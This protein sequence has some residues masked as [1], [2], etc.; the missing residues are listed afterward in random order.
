[1]SRP[2]PFALACGLI[3]LGSALLSATSAGAQTADEKTKAQAEI[4]TKEQ[5]V[6]YG[7]ADGNMNNYM[8]ATHPDYMAWP[9]WAEA[10]FG[11]EGLKRT[12]STLGGD[13]EKLAME[14][15]DFTM[16]GDTALIYYKTHRTALGD[17]TPV[18]QVYENIHVW[19]RDGG[20]WKVMGGMAREKAKPKAP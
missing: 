9:P 10:P 15:K 6:Y 19:K 4:W 20:E 3:L 8:Q 7:R 2:S 18:D 12:Q 13:K 16:N 5:S 11:A 14:F 17:G 1:M